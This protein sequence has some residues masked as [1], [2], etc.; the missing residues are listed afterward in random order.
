[1]LLRRKDATLDTQ[2]PEA[3]PEYPLQIFIPFTTFEN[4]QRSI[5]HAEQ[6]CSGLSALIRII[7]TQQVPYPLDLDHPAMAESTAQMEMSRLE[8]G[9]PI[10]AE[11]WLCRDSVSGLLKALPPSSLVILTYRRK[12]LLTREERLGRALKRAG[13]RVSMFLQEKSRV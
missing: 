12:L 3:S 13:H 2:R 5:E 1:M 11:M 8:S 10:T 6:L 4:T 7:R 9:L